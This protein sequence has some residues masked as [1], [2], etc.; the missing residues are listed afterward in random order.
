MQIQERPAHWPDF[1]HT[2]P[3][4]IAGRYMRSFWQ[5]VFLS[6]SLPRLRAKPLKVM[7]EM[8]TLYRDANGVARVA[9]DRCLH[10]GTALWTGTVEGESIRCLY[11][12][13]RYDAQGRCVERPAEETCPERLRIRTYPAREWAGLVF[14][15]LGEGEPPEFPMLDGFEGGALVATA[16]VR[17]FNYFNQME[18]GVDE[19]HFNFVH[20]VSRFSSQ[21]MNAELPI[22]DCEETAYGLSRTATRGDVVRRN[23]F[24]MPNANTSILFGAQRLVWRVPI[25]DVSHHSFTV[26]CFHGTQEQER[27]W[28][29]EQQRQLEAMANARPAADVAAAILRGELTLDEVVDH[30][31]LLSVQDG[32]ALLGQGTIANRMNEVLG[33][34]DLQIVRLRRLW[35]DDFAALQ[36]GRAPRRWKWPRSVPLTTGLK[37]A[38]AA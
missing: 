21:G 17:P 3:G 38:A 4:T 24:L 13:W 31:D 1:E 28:F 23:H 8:F 35:A 10:R 25:D 14:A 30:P 12:G 18:N 27:D 9:A 16:P 11:H 6:A 5:P 19:V 36:E 2:G 15:Y 26:D 7:G 22:L 29:S 37:A 32:V 33:R 20:R 34:S